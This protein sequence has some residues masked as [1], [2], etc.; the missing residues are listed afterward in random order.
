L[1]KNYQL[2]RKICDKNNMNPFPSWRGITKRRAFG[3]IVGVAL[4]ATI[5]VGGVGAY[6]KSDFGATLGRRGVRGHEDDHVG[7]SAKR[8]RLVQPAYVGIPM[9]HYDGGVYMDEGEMTTRQLQEKSEL[10]L[11]PTQNPTLSS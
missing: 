7:S 5:L 8:R 4:L 10:T 6:G 2:N 11:N 1:A 9:I 3:T